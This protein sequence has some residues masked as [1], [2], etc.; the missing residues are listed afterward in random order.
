M[1]TSKGNAG[2]LVPICCLSFHYG[3]DFRDPKEY[4]CHPGVRATQGLS[5]NGFVV[6][7]RYCGGEGTILNVDLT[8]DKIEKEP[9]SPDFARKYLGAS[10]FNSIRLFELVKPEVDGLSP[11]NVLIVGA[12]PL[13]LTRGLFHSH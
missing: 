8:V 1:G 11:E 3:W 12:G 4:Y 5:I 13:S 6:M 10:S 7:V 9:L 2:A